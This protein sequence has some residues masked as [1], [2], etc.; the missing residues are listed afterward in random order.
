M[1]SVLNLLSGAVEGAF[2]EGLERN[3]N[4]QEAKA[5]LE[6]DAAN[7]GTVEKIAALIGMGSIS[8]TVVAMGYCA[9]GRVDKGKALIFLAVP[10]ATYSY[11]CYQ[12]SENFRTQ[13]DEN[14]APLMV[15]TGVDDPVDVNKA[16]LR[17]CLLNR[18]VF[19]EPCLDLYARCCLINTVGKADLS[20]RH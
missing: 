20:T 2:K 7:A 8:L 3:P 10:L 16:A 18:T 19:F 17:R 1:S 4:Y 13:V 14:P 6:A 15:I 12:A 5:N 9:S 11:N